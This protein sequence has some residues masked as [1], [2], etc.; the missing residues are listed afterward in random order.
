M[1][2]LRPLKQLGQEILSTAKF[3]ILYLT[4]ASNPKTGKITL[5]NGLSDLAI[6]NVENTCDNRILLA[7]FLPDDIDEQEV[8]A[9]AILL[10]KWNEHMRG[11]EV[12]D[13]ESLQ[14]EHGSQLLEL[15]DI[16]RAPEDSDEDE[17]NESAEANQAEF[18]EVSEQE[19]MMIDDEAGQL[20]SMPADAEVMQQV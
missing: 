14:E 1:E 4:L 2:N 7:A 12:H 17:Q 5:A 6:Y 18:V 10:E 16:A 15:K 3:W 13:Y 9:D 8:Q 20:P 19:M 11:V